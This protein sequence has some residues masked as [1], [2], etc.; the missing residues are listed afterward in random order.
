MTYEEAKEI[1]Y[2]MTETE[3]LRKHAHT[4]SE[5]MRAMAKKFGG[6]EEKFAIVGLLHDADYEKYPDKHPGLIVEK[7][8]EREEHEL[9]HAI[10][11]HYTIWNVPRESMLDKCIVAAD[12]LTGFIIAASLV[13]PT[14]LEGMK[15]KSVMKKLKTTTFAAKVDREE[16]RKG[17]ELIG[18]DLKDL[19]DFIIE[20]LQQ[21]Q[22]SLGLN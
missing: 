14:G 1:L 20:V 2:E 15:A 7:L 16:V 4:V 6:D 21:K 12:E 18:M 11:G 13:R 5:V 9:A 22:E 10:A 19:I 3:S 8:R 17:A